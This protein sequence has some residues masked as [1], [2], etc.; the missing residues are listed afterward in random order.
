MVE[1]ALKN[2]LGSPFTTLNMVIRVMQ[3]QII[4]VV[5][6][7]VLL[8][9]V[10]SGFAFAQEKASIYVGAF[11]VTPSVDIDIEND[12]NVFSAASG[13]ET[14]STLTLVRPAILAVADDGV[15]RYA[16]EYQL[17]NGTYANTNNSDYT[18]H[19]LA[20]TMDW[21]IDVRHLLEF[22]TSLDYGHD[23][24]APDN[25]AGAGATELNKST[26][27]GLGVNYTLGSEGAQGRLTIGFETRSLR[28]TTNRA[29]T[30]VLESDTDIANLGFAV[31]FIPTTRATFQVS[32]TKNIFSTN[33]VN[34]RTDL[35]YLVGMEWDFSGVTKGNI[36]IGRADNDLHN[37]PGDTST[38]TGEISVEWLA[39]E[40]STWTLTAN[41]SA[42]NSE[43]NI[44]AFVDRSELSLVWKHN[45]TEG[46]STQFSIERQGDDFVGANRSDDTDILD[47]ELT[48]TL[49]RWLSI[50]V[51]VGKE[52][53]NS[54]DRQ[55]NYTKN[56]AVFSI[57]A[58][59]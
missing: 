36:R 15:V 39:Q 1:L 20:A 17:E 18:D 42:E 54:T 12:D 28:Y 45:W 25:V 21:R 2:G 55:L 4:A 46:L 58:S 5:F 57:K 59:L 10:T 48:Y 47:V 19:N 11:D 30:N 53:R 24:R 43:N 32:E 23:E 34:N 50:G 9:V 14:R 3:L 22:S 27:K 8:L 44:G 29:T 38:S 31:A 35:N 33:S 40:F 51:S 56:T 37:V 13:S 6:R 41:K 26:N 52:K 49:R 16:M 7:C